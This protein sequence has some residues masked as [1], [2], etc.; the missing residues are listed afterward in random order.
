MPLDPHP[1]RAA[2]GHNIAT[3]EASGKKHRQAVAI[4]LAKLRE[5]KKRAGLKPIPLPPHGKKD[6]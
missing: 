5:A 6:R 3:E 2:V 1:T 4:A